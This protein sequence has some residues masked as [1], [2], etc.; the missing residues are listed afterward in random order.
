[1][2]TIVTAIA[3]AGLLSLAACSGGSEGENTAT[4]N[5]TAV[6]E[7]GLENEAGNLG[8]AANSTV[9]G[10]VDTLGNQASALENGVSNGVGNAADATGNALGNA[11][12]AT[13]NAAGNV[14]NTAGNTL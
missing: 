4:T 13:G 9:N 8:E 5:D 1:M 2:K 11:A 10:Q 6:S 12:D 3:A 14:A 7:T